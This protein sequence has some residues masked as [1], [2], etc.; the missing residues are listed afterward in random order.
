MK[1]S[2]LVLVTGATGYVG[3]RLV[4]KLLQSGYRVRVLVRDAARLEGRSWLNKVEVSVG[5]VFEPETL[6]TAMKNVGV[7]YYMIHSMMDSHEF[8]ERDVIAARNFGK[9]AKDGG[10]QRII[11]LGGLGEPEADLSQHLR[12]RQQTGQVLR[13]SGVPLTEFRAAIIVGSG[14]I[15]FEMIRYLTERLPVMICPQWVFTKVQPVSISDVL[16][17]LVSALETPGSTGKIIEIGG[18]EV[19]TY[20]EMMTEYASVRGLKRWLIPVPVLTPRLSSHWVHW[21]TPIPSEIAAPLIEGLRNEVILHN[22]LAVQLFPGIVPIG[23]R[24]AVEQAL[25]HLKAGSIESSWSDSLASSQGDLPTVGLTTQEG[26][27]VERRQIK[28]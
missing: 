12:S 21:I 5:D 11:Y 24:L 9:A 18:N 19:L 13:E 4:P 6:T 1:S 14:S 25:D 16:A 2:K 15:S 22:D 20:G 7:A 10:V 28:S 26:M 27:I 17:Y 8:Y 3:G 23:Y